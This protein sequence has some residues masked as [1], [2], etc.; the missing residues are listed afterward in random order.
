MIYVLEHYISIFKTHIIMRPKST[1]ETGIDLIRTLI[2]VI[3]HIYVYLLVYYISIR[4]ILLTYRWKPCGHLS[5]ER[6]QIV[7]FPVWTKVQRM[8]SFFILFQILLL[9]KHVPMQHYQ[10]NKCD[11]SDGLI[12]IEN[13]AALSQWTSDSWNKSS[14]RLPYTPICQHQWMPC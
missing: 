13:Y 4:K 7:L 1:A 8:G 5:R 12:K 9:L 10:S 3:R 2:R 14:Q 6:M 11:K